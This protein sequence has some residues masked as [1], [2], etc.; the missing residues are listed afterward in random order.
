[1]G[2]K[3][4]YGPGLTV[5]TNSVF[6]VV[7]QFV[8]NTGTTSGTMNEIRRF[9][10]Q[11]GVII[12]NSQSTI[13][14][15]TGNSLTT[16]FCNAQKTAFGD[17]NDFA[18]HGGFSSMSS[19][20]SGGMVLVLSLWDDYAANMLWLDS[21]YPTSSPSTQPGIA[22][23]SCATNSGVPAT[24]EANNANAYVIYSNIRV[25]PINS[26]FSG[27]LSGGGTGGS[28]SSSSAGVSSTSATS[29]SRTSSSTASSST[30]AAQWA[31]CG[32]QGWT[33]P[34]TCVSP[35]TCTV[36]NNWY[37]QCL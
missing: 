4:F 10:V 35:Y 30:G 18:T 15:V 12:P 6:T 37:S 11:N 9:Y 5:N 31:Q 13:S 22:R 23:G 14:G 24:V 26:T 25:G 2:N 27:T 8:T 32:G 3:T 21:S 7:T 16:A 19:A 28:S 29:S 33:G 20:M 1:M 34:T 36:S 17:V